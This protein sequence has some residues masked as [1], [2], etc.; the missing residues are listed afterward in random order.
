MFSKV[1]NLLAC[2][3]VVSVLIGGSFV[4]KYG[5]PSPWLLKRKVITKVRTIAKQYGFEA[6]IAPVDRY[7]DHVFTGQMVTTHPRVLFG[8]KEAYEQL[9]RRYN[10]D[11]GFR[12]SVDE[13]AKGKS[14][15]SSVVAWVCKNDRQAGLR[16][17]Q[18]LLDADIQTPDNDGGKSKEGLAVA[19]AYD[20]LGNLPDWDDGSRMRMSEKLARFVKAGL[21][22]LNNDSASL[23]HGRFELSCAVWVAAVAMDDLYAERS[24]LLR[25]SQGHFYSALVAIELTEGWPEG[26]TYWINNRAFAFAVACAAHINGVDAP[27]INNRIRDVIERVAL[28]TIYGTEPTGRFV[29]FGDAGPRNDLKDETQRVVDTFYMLTQ[30]PVINDYSRY[31]SGLHRK[32][33]YDGPYRWGVPLLRGLTNDALPDLSSFAGR[34]PNS[35][36]FGPNALGQVFIRSDWGP[37]ATF[38]SYQAG[39][40][41]THH[42]HYQA[43]HFTITKKAPLAITSGSYGKYFDEHRLNYYI[44]TV[45]SN[46]ILVMKPSEEVRPNRYFKENV[47]DG[48]QR[49]VMPTGSTIFS[50]TDWMDRLSSGPHYEG[51]KILAF[52][53]TDPRFV[54]VNSDLTRAYN[55]SGFDDNGDGGK[56]LEVNRQLLYLKD[57]DILLVH[58]VIDASDESYTKKWLLHSWGRPETANEKILVGDAD[59]GILETADTRA[60]IQNGGGV[61]EVI[62]LLPQDAVMRKVG[63]PDYKYYVEVDGDDSDFDGRNMVGGVREEKWFDSGMWRLEIQPPLGRKRDQFL[64]ALAPRSLGEKEK[65][66]VKLVTAEGGNAVATTRA[67]VVFWEKGCRNLHYVAAGG[68]RLLNIIANVP[69]GQQVQVA[70]GGSETTY[71]AS[72]KGTVVFETEGGL[73][74]D[75]LLTFAL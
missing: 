49:I 15:F 61:L 45:S 1:R 68:E 35:D 57:D 75:V 5:V 12:R 17:R 34:L 71:I 6:L 46:S 4:L 8:S 27:E 11:P 39:D 30:N 23:W 21:L 69:P 22:V 67:V 25:Q 70:I 20:L 2:L 60:V 36:I 48:G 72:T 32:G 62:R 56:V 38:I 58:D 43:G 42:G 18:A 31:I 24:E 65:T 74:S 26:Y 51:G 28:W 41:L 50:V 54:Y 53:N 44:R 33:G 66:E 47:A 40:S 73:D 13:Q 52:Q 64:V 14:Y 29:L 7:K 55:N 37:D 59:N 9:Q 10:E 63:G 16:G 19:L 3:G